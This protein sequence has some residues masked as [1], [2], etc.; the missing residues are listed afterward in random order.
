M[1]IWRKFKIVEK[2]SRLQREMV[3]LEIRYITVSDDRLAISKVYEEMLQKLY[4]GVWYTIYVDVKIRF[5]RRNL[6]GRE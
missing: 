2:D 3:I 6:W 1:C 5:C 4:G